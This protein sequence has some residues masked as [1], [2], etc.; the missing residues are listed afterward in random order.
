M[1]NDARI[2]ALVMLALSAASVLPGAGT[3][4]GPAAQDAL[5]GSSYCASPLWTDSPGLLTDVALTSLGSQAPSWGCSGNCTGSAEDAVVWFSPHAWLENLGQTDVPWNDWLGSAQSAGVPPYGNRQHP[6]LVWNLYRVDAAGRI[7]QIGRS[8]VKHAYFAANMQCDC[9]GGHVFWA[10]DRVPNGLGCSDVYSA[11]NNNEGRRLGPRSEILP[12]SATWGRCGSV[13]DPDCDGI[14]L[15][16][17]L[18]APTFRMQVREADLAAT[19]NPGAEYL[20]EAW[21]LV[22]GDALRDNSIR[23]VRA[24]TNWNGSSW[25][26]LVFVPESQRSGPALDSWV[27]PGSGSAMAMQSHAGAGDGELRL[28]VRVTALEGGR[29]RYDYALLN[30]DVAHPVTEGGEPNLRVLSNRGIDRFA[31][32]LPTASSIDGIEFADGTGLAQ[33]WSAS[34]AQGQLTFAAGPDSASL[35]WGSLFRFSLVADRPPVRGEAIAGFGR[36]GYAASYV[37]Q[38]LLPDADG[39]FRD[40]F[41]ALS[42][43]P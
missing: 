21:Y 27:E 20:L 36:D 40:G 25:S 26:A 35:D 41:E 31:L 29:Y 42:A 3:P 38:T 17:G 37:L 12:A 13:F 32:P 18:A 8:G 19:L 15:D 9:N 14:A 4:R 5:K 24:S 39:V 16:H 10:A 22:R 30:L 43:T 33:P 11:A 7:E 2:S 1:H 28:A 6:L 23:H 34:Q